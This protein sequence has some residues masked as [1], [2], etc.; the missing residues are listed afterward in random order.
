MDFKAFHVIA[1]GMEGVLEVL[2]FET[3]RGTEFSA[4]TA[5]GAMELEIDKQAVDF[6]C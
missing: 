5:A 4:E 6:F 3:Q 1:T 2:F